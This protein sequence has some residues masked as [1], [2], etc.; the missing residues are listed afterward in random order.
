MDLF[1][2]LFNEQIWFG[3]LCLELRNYKGERPYDEIIL[4]RLEQAQNTI[5]S[6]EKYKLLNSPSNLYEVESEELWQWYALGRLNDYL[7]MRFQLRED[8]YRA[9]VH[10]SPEWQAW[11]K[12]V[13]H[14]HFLNWEGSVI[15]EDQYI[16]FFDS[17]G[18]HSFTNQPYH[19]FYY[20]IVEAVET[21]QLS[22]EIRVDHVFWPGLMFGNMM[23]SRAGVRVLFRSCILEKA[24]AEN[25]RLY[26]TYWRFRRET[27]DL[28]HGWG[29]NSQ[30]RTNFRR[31]YETVAQYH[32]NVDGYR[33]LG[34]NHDYR[35]YLNEEE[36]DDLTMTERIELLV[37][38]CFVSCRKKDIDRW[39]FDDRYDIAKNR[40]T[41]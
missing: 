5:N 39:P 14:E 30:W 2:R 26:F 3:E 38:R 41:G 16:E 32:F 40:K 4:P 8:F 35:A 29:H 13:G 22:E 20:E 37:N 33:A 1:S 25:S 9:T 19:P 23:F 27:A 10:Q 7:L 15:S 34:E 17:L 18:F 21:P 31:D 6:L 24:I 36:P 11:M 28:S 12:R